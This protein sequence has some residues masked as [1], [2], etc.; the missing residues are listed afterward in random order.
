MIYSETNVTFEWIVCLKGNFRCR[1]KSPRVKWLQA[2]FVTNR[3]AEE[4]ETLSNALKF[5]VVLRQR[6]D[7]YSEHN[8]IMMLLHS[9]MSGLI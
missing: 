3:A 1:C 6:D 7:E 9:E 4:L 2:S 5:R 8:R